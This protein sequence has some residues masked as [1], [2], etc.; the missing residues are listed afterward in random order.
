[1]KETATVDLSKSAEA[2]WSFMWDPASSLKLLDAEVAVALP[3]QEGVGEIQAFVER[4]QGVRV[5]LLHEVIEF[6]PGHRAVTRSLVGWCPS[7][8]ALTIEP[9]GPNSCRLTQEFWAEVPAGVPAG[10]EQ[11][12]RREFRQ[13]LETMM[14]RLAEWAVGRL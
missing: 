11:Q 3:G 10:T 8:G 7:W 2:A 14:R 5:G 9:L 4:V 6:D 13:R 1:M 12:Q